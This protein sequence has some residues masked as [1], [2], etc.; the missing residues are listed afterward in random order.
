MF[1]IGTIILNSLVHKVTDRS[2]DHDNATYIS[3]STAEERRDAIQLHARQ[4]LKLVALLLLA[5]LFALGVIADILLFGI[6]MRLH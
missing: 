6:A 3:M 4:D 5:I 2:Y 1:T